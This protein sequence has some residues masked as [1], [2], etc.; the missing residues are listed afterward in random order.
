MVKFSEIHP[1]ILLISRKCK[2]PSS[3]K[4]ICILPRPRLYIGVLFEYKRSR[5]LQQPTTAMH[6][7]G[8]D[9][10]QNSLGIGT[11]FY[12][13]FPW[14]YPSLLSKRHLDRFSRFCTV[15]CV[16]VF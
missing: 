16:P 3:N 10:P 8:I 12:R 11:P 15:H 7:S 6:F 9:T 14:A 2:F 4:Y 5:I 13:M 1:S